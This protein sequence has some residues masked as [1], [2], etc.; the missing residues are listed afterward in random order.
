MPF[1]PN[2]LYVALDEQD[3]V[4]Y[5]ACGFFWAELSSAA[6]VALQIS[7]NDIAW[8]NIPVADFPLPI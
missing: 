4:W 7:N 1:S 6:D 8:L 5:L 2:E 3:R